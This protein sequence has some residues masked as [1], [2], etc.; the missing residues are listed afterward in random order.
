MGEVSGFGWGKR[1]MGTGEKDR[2]RERGRNVGEGG[3]RVG[4]R[5]Q[6]AESKGEG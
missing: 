6:R 4:R 5:G 2:T 3:V 1:A